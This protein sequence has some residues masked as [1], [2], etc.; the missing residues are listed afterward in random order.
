M[1][2]VNI[3]YWQNLTEETVSSSYLVRMRYATCHV[4]MPILP[5]ASTRQSYLEHIHIRC[6]R[7]SG[8]ARAPDVFDELLLLFLL[9]L[10]ILTIWKK[11]KI[12]YWGD[13][14]VGKNIRGMRPPF[15]TE[16]MPVYYY[17]HCY[18]QLPCKC[19]SWYSACVWGHLLTDLNKYVGPLYCWATMY[20]G[21][22]LCCPW[23]DTMS[24]LIGQTDRRMDARPL[25]YAFR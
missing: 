11:T 23:W 7:W 8:V 12:N 10:S 13:L 9:F 22:V 2:N 14:L 16:L 17:I 18:N 19:D 4:Y 20:V 25:H 15:P 21:R 1:A 5:G 3:S 6:R 24:M